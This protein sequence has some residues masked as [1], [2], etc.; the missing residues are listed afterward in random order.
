MVTVSRISLVYECGYK[1]FS[2][3]GIFVK[4][5][6]FTEDN[7]YLKGEAFVDFFEGLNSEEDFEGRIKSLNG[8][9][10]VIY[11]RNK[12]LFL[13]TDL[14]RNFPI[15]YCKKG[16]EISVS[17]SVEVLLEDDSE[18]SG[19]SKKEFLATGFVTNKFT[20]IEGIVQVQAGSIVSFFGDDVRE[21]F[22]HHFAKDFPYSS[23]ITLS[24]EDIFERVSERLLTVLD[25]RTA[26]I[27]LSGGY[28]S[29][30]IACILKKINYQHIVCYSFGIASSEEVKM[31]KKV[32]KELGFKWLFVPCDE[33]RMKGFP[34]SESFEE[35]YSYASNFVSCFFTQHYFA[36]RYLYQND[37]I[38]KNSVFLPGH[39]GDMLSGSHLSTKINDDTLL[40][41]VFKKHYWNSG[42]YQYVK[43]RISLGLYSIKA[44]ENFDN[45]NL[46]ERQAKFIINSCRVDEYFGYEYYLP[47]WDKELVVFFENASFDERL[48]QNIYI[49]IIF[50]YYFEPLNVAFRKLSSRENPLRC[51]VKGIF[52]RIKRIVYT[53]DLNCK[54][55]AKKMLKHTIMD[56]HWNSV[57]INSNEISAAWYVKQLEKKHNLKRIIKP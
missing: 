43:T 11:H 38:P 34:H 27:P 46:K 17:D 30:L 44:F 41:M 49:K 22:Y 28:D 48:K 32:A 42:L 8:Q 12:Q 51:L 40:K 47:L 1:W 45:W 56:I 19:L 16:F 31:S 50:K 20:L 29:R 23:S 18:F 53:D 33:E 5:F 6:A 21:K 24:L 36:V 13:A 10:S 26:V 14:C 55:T 4:G 39:S 15:F 35:Y 52:R 54:L 2:H 9:F 25:G 7:L 3:E 57:S 37:L